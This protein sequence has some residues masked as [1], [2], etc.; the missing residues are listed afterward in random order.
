MYKFDLAAA[1]VRA[2]IKQKDA[3]ETFG[4]SKPTLVSWEKGRTEPSASQIPLILETY[5]LPF[6]AMDFS[7]HK[8]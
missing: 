4:I 6:E 2:G 3:A 8:T 1:R 5:G 7:K